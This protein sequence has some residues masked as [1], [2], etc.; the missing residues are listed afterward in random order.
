MVAN[1]K[2]N[3]VVKE[4]LNKSFKKANVNS[5]IVSVANLF[6]DDT[7]TV[8]IF[9]N[10]KYL[11][12][13]TEKI[14]INNLKKDIKLKKLVIKTPKISIDDNINKVIR[15]MLESNIYKLPV[16]DRDKLV[17]IVDI[18]TILNASRFEG[19]LRDYI[20]PLDIVVSPE[21]NINSVLN[22]LRENN[23][24]SLPVVDNEKVVGVITVHSIIE[25]IH[26][27]ENKG[28]YKGIS[29]YVFNN[30]FVNDLMFSDVPVLKPYES[31]GKAIS[32]LKEYE[33]IVVSDNKIITTFCKKD[34]LKSL[35][36]NEHDFEINITDKTRKINKQEI[37][38]RI[39]GFLSNHKKEIGT[40][41]VNLYIKKDANNYFG[42]L[43]L[44]TERFKFDLKSKNKNELIMLSDLIHKLKQKVKA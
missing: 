31:I 22:I 18:D 24:D 8:F 9:D 7:D 13:V 20:I 43:K 27:I 6:F 3:L 38:S 41:R 2:S 32:L 35:I 30:L 10:N 4:L 44:S 28:K 19:V 17:G 29:N 26:F 40:G 1:P 37:V 16:F 25:K 12:I 21:Q 42:K 11:G 15:L 34:I 39:Q 14:I 23:I 5:S 36:K 33:H